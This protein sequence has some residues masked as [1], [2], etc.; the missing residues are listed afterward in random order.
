MRV[1]SL[2]GASFW[3]AGGEPASGTAPEPKRPGCAARSCRATSATA[4]DCARGI[5]TWHTRRRRHAAGRRAGGAG[6]PRAR[7]G[8]RRSCPRPRRRRP[9]RGRRRGSRV[10]AAG[11]ARAKAAPPRCQPPGGPSPTRA[12][13]RHVRQA[14]HSAAHAAVPGAGT[15]IRGAPSQTCRRSRAHRHRSPT[16]HP[17]P[18]R[19]QGA[20]ARCRRHRRVL[21]PAGCVTPPPPPPP[22]PPLSPNSPPCVSRRTPST[23][24]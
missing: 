15:R 6:A 3:F 12:A 23:Q 14:R 24:L 4:R 2:S 20:R 1:D 8:Q 22:P 17:P 11:T 7:D 16:A 13:R 21:G 18:P 9:C 10:G 19:R 5:G